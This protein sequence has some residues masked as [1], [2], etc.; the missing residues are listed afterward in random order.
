M[1]IPYGFD[2]SNTERRKR[3][4]DSQIK[5]SEKLKTRIM[6]FFKNVDSNYS[7]TKG[8][9]KEIKNNIINHFKQL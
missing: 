2:E 5:T 1:N 9:K 8:Q 4:F 3:I 7:L 6:H